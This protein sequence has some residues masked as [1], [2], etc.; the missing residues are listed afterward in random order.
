MWWAASHEGI[1]SLV[2]GEYGW[3]VGLARAGPLPGEGQRGQWVESLW[4]SGGRDVPP[5][6]V[7]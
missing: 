5:V 1:V 4:E 7:G 6:P 3:A 2:G